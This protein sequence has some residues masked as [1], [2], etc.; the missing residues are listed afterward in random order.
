MCSVGWSLFNNHC[1]KYFPDVATWSAAKS[2][3]ESVG[4]ILASVHSTEENNFVH[5]LTSQ[6]TWLGGNDINS[7]G[8]WVWEDGENWGGFT[9]WFSGEPNNGGDNEDCLEIRYSDY[10]W[11]DLACGTAISYVCKI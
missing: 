4:S 6:S 8:V 3:C 1:Y 7:E 10:K 2:S 9:W 5:S 11:N